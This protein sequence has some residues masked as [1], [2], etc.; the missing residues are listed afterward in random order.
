MSTYLGYKLSGFEEDYA[1]KKGECKILFSIS[2]H[3]AE[4]MMKKVIC[5]HQKFRR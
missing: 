4:N 2:P 1:D 5:R 3:E